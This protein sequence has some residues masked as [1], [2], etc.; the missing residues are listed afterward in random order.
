MCSENDA[1]KRRFGVSAPCAREEKAW[2]DGHTA[3]MSRSRALGGA[4]ARAYRPQALAIVPHCRLGRSVAWL[5]PHREVART[6]AH[7]DNLSAFPRGH[8]WRDGRDARKHA[9]HIHVCKW[10]QRLE[11]V[12]WVWLDVGGAQAHA[13][14]RDQAI[15][16]T[17][18]IRLGHACRTRL[19]IRHIQRHH[20][21]LRTRRNSDVSHR[22]PPLSCTP[23]LPFS[24]CLLSLCRID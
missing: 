12:I 24:L 19:S 4:N 22:T 23:T 3:L 16:R 20:R 8:L 14:V 11:D 18:R 10:H 2:E 21:H 17:P 7:D 5:I 13:G 6:A 9:A 15:D 1:S